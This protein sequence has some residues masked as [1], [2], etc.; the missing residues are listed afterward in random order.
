MT[1]P[2]ILRQR[3]ESALPSIHLC[4]YDICMPSSFD[5]AKDAANRKKHGIS[6]FEGNP[7]L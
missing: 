6:L 3:A 2:V 7:E 5:P 4:A 1:Y